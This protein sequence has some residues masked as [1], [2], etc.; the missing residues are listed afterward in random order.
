MSSLDRVKNGPRGCFTA[1][2]EGQ[3]SIDDN[4]NARAQ[5]QSQT[6]SNNITQSSPMPNNQGPSISPIEEEQTQIDD[7]N[8]G[9]NCRKRKLTSVVWNHF[10][11]VN[12]NG[13]DKVEC[14]DCKKKLGANSKNGTRHLH[15]HFK[16]C[17]W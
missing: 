1:I 7:R 14:R 3:R 17:P 2:M 4:S 8:V 9:T 5:A 16:S 11:K 10:E 13:E 6:E 12:V 15:D